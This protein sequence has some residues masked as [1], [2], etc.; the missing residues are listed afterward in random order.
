[1]IGQSNRF[2]LI[3]TNLMSDHDKRDKTARFV[4]YRS[5]VSLAQRCKTCRYSYGPVRA[6][7]QI[8]REMK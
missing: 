8:I 4:N 2:I 6:N 3:I 5:T 7:A 1:M